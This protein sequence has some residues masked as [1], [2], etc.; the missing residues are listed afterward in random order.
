MRNVL[1]VE[2]FLVAICVIVYIRYYAYF[3]FNFTICYLTI[4]NYCN[5]IEIHLLIY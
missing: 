5:S 1:S 3:N 4:N 2:I